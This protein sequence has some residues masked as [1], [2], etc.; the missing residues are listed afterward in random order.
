MSGFRSFIVG[1][2]LFFQIIYILL[3]TAGAGFWGYS[4]AHLFNSNPLLRAGQKPTVGL[5]VSEIAGALLGGFFGFAASA[6]MA[7]LLFLFVAIEK[8]TR[9]TAYLLNVIKGD[10]AR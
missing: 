5:Q 7:A 3:S 2:V 8:N 1:L 4:I 9:N 6:T 10:E